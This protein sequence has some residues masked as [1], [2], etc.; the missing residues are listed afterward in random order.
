[1]ASETSP[2]IRSLG[3]AD[4]ERCCAISAQAHWN[5]T[6]SDWNFLFEN[7]CT[8]GVEI[9]DRGLVG[10]T[11]AWPIS[12]E[13]AWI[14]MVL[15]DEVCRG[16]GLAK[17]MFER[18]LDDLKSKGVTSFLD[19]TAMGA[20]VYR[21]F[22][23][24][25]SAEFVRLKGS[26]AQLRES[27]EVAGVTSADVKSDLAEIAQWDKQVLG[28]DRESF[29]RRLMCEAPALSYCHRDKNHRLDGFALGRRGRVA[30][31]IGPV[32]ALDLADAQALISATA[33][34]IDGAVYI[35]V[36][37]VARG[38]ADWLS[39]RGFEV[40]RRFLRMGLD[41]AELATD[42]SRYFAIAGPDYG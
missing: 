27:S 6:S 8:Y 18:C 5:Q 26:A 16:R 1:M 22:G 15:V 37:V 19:A 2:L 35:D 42:W 31:Q 7:A 4:L 32:V 40:E 24:E 12:A 11:V 36:P 34:A 20:R 41:G 38:L 3:P 25:A 39:E 30:T 10:T 17:A 28:G 13:H 14:N 29:V 33:N 23:F 21:K 9:S